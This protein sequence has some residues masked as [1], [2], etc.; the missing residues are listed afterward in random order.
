MW[1]GMAKL[2]DRIWTTGKRNT[3]EGLNW[4]CGV[5]ST[6]IRIDMSS[7]HSRQSG[8]CRFIRQEQ[9]WIKVDYTFEFSFVDK[10]LSPW[11]LLAW[12]HLSPC[13]LDHLIMSAELLTH[14]DSAENTLKINQSFHILMIKFENLPDNGNFFP[15]MLNLLLNVF[16]IVV[17][18][19]PDAHVG[20]SDI[21]WDVF[22]TVDFVCCHH[23]AGRDCNRITPSVLFLTFSSTNKSYQ[24]LFVLVWFSKI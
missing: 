4:A 14:P 2:A 16:L 18:N 12:L 24:T 23:C 5:D 22:F 6:C 10:S 11:P 19:L 13:C 17:Q 15:T 1:S 7:I 21:W 9:I 3:F 8:N 20:S